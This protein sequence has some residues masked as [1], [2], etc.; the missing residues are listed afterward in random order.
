MFS[1]HN[2]YEGDVIVIICTIGTRQ[3]NSLGGAF[4]TLTHFKA[5][6]SIANH[7]LSCL[8]LFITDDIH[9]IG[10]PQLYHLLRTFSI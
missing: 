5:L 8:F 10:P 3:G 6:H 9:I 2:V 1:N 7:F 4:F